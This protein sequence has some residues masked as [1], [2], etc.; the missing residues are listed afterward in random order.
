MPRLRIAEAH[1]TTGF[2]P[3][4]PPLLAVGISGTLATFLVAYGFADIIVSMWI[5]TD[6][7]KE[8]ASR[9]S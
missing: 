2:W 1:G 6:F 7:V 9:T 8:R 3:A 5:K 4:V